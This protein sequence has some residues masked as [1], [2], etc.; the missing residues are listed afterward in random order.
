MAYA[1][2][3]SSAVRCLLFAVCCLLFPV[4]CFLFAVFCL[5]FSVCCLLFAVCSLQF[6]TCRLMFDVCCLQFRV[7]CL[8][9]AACCLLFAVFC[10]LFA[11]NTTD[12]I[13][14][15]LFLA[16]WIII[17]KCFEPSKLKWSCVWYAWAFGSL[18]MHFC[19]IWMI[20]CDLVTLPKVGKHLVLSQYVISS[21]STRPNSRT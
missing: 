6:A 9:F 18:K 13:W 20:L 1:Q 21:R 4:C 3:Q 15:N 12:P 17:Q 2:L 14:E 10:L 7:C 19:D 16:L 5:P 11:V 8:L